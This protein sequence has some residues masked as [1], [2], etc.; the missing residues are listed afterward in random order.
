LHILTLDKV[1]SSGWFCSMAPDIQI[2]N[3]T[4]DDKVIYI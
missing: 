3:R 4:F 2:Y 1:H